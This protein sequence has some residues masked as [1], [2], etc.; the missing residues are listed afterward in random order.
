MYAPLTFHA[1]DLNPTSNIELMGGLVAKGR[2]EQMIGPVTPAES[3]PES[4]RGTFSLD[5]TITKDDLVP[6]SETA[7]TQKREY[8]K[9]L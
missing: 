4:L 5:G 1:A 7:R 9:G 8:I 6:V 2:G 3:V